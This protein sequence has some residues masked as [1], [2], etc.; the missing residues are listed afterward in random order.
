MGK[1]EGNAGKLRGEILERLK[2]VQDPE[3]KMDVVSLG[4]I[5]EVSV[6]EEGKVSIVFRPTSPLCPLAFKIALDIRD[7]AKEVEGVGE[8]EVEAVDFLWAN[9]LREFLRGEG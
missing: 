2:E 4:L 9:Q 1:G 5:R 6:D 7:A 3:L 8:V